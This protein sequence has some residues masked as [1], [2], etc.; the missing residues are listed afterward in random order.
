[1]NKVEFEE[2]FLKR[3]CMKSSND[4]V[5]DRNFWSLIL[6]NNP[7]SFNIYHFHLYLYPLMQIVLLSRNLLL[8]KSHKERISE[9]ICD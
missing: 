9:F 8:R 1:M 2:C 6:C 5:V 4:C 3:S 7:E